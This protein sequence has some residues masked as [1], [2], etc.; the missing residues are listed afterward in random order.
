MTR[1]RRTKGNEKQ[2]TVSKSTVSTSADDEDEQLQEE[3]DESDFNSA[4]AVSQAYDLLDNAM[5]VLDD[6]IQQQQPA[7][8]IPT[9]V[10]LA[11]PPGRSTR[12]GRMTGYSTTAGK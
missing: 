9:T 6:M 4:V 7:L 12:S 11:L 8:P 10:S 1:E 5:H 2:T 3:D